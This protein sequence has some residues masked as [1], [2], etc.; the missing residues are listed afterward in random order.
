MGIVPNTRGPGD[1]IAV[2]QRRRGVPAASEGRPER[3]NS[4]IGQAFVGL[5]QA[6]YT[7]GQVRERDNTILVGL[8][9]APPLV[10]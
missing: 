2:R 8:D 9:R 4:L 10:R 5:V 7:T 1:S 3:F 6:G